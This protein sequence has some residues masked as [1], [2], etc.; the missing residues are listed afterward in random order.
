MK[1]PTGLTR[2]HGSS[3]ILQMMPATDSIIRQI[4]DLGYAVSTH[5]MGGCAEMHAV[6]LPRVCF[7]PT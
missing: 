2:C 5:R 3:A 6:P 4:E 1:R 7:P